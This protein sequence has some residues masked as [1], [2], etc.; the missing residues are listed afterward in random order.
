METEPG[1]SGVPSTGG[2]DVGVQAVASSKV[3][4]YNIPGMPF[5][6]HQFGTPVPSLRSSQPREHLPLVVAFPL[7]ASPGRRFCRTRGSSKEVSRRAET[8]SERERE[9]ERERR[10]ILSRKDLLSGNR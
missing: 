2:D 9:R 5:R 7:L 10:G 3:R 1:T 8:R 6:V 4:D